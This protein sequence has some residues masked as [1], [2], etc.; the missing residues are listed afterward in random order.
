VKKRSN[1]KGAEDWTD[2]DYMAKWKANCIVIA[3][4]CWEWQGFLHEFRNIKPGQKGYPGTS[5]RG[6][7]VRLH[8][9]VLEL[10]L[11]RLLVTGELACHSCDYPPCIN[12]EHLEAGTQEKNKLDEVARGRSF[13]AN[14]TRCKRG[15]SFDEDNTYHL[16]GLKGRPRRMCRTCQRDRQRETWRQRN[17]YY[18][19]P[20]EQK[21]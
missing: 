17:G 14:K 12:P 1:L 3:S 15:H 13:Y 20:Q 4:G 21:E 2:A 9:K 8:K 7:R 19:T 10:K 11:G 6:K 18:S 16:L 5:Y